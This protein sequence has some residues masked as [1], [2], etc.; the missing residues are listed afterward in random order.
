MM[1]TSQA[2]RAL[3][4]AEAMEKAAGAMPPPISKQPTPDWLDKK[5][6]PALANPLAGAAGRGGASLTLKPTRKPSAATL[7]ANQLGGMGIASQGEAAG[8]GW[9]PWLAMP[10]P[11]SSETAQFQRSTLTE[12]VV[13]KLGDGFVLGG[14]KDLEGAPGDGERF[15]PTL[16][17]VSVWGLTAKE[18]VNDLEGNKIGEILYQSN[19]IR[20]LQRSARV[21][22]N[23]GTTLFTFD[24]PKVS[25][26]DKN[27]A[28]PIM[29]HGTT[30]Y[31]SVAV[32]ASPK[33]QNYLQGQLTRLDG[34]GGLRIGKRFSKQG[35]LA[36]LFAAFCFPTLIL[37]FGCVFIEYLMQHM[38]VIIALESLDGATQFT[39]MLEVKRKQMVPFQS[40]AFPLKHAKHAKKYVEEKSPQPLDGAARIDALILFVVSKAALTLCET[41][42]TPTTGMVRLETV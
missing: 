30:P 2:D 36:C 9:R 22:V 23:D 10:M 27:P 35:Y 39:P 6:H 34:S 20:E 21:V 7:A 13:A 33:F 12:S 24:R 40:A 31:A 38:P 8:S 25:K 29:L 37:V 16:G 18:D 11:E 28:Y 42:S 41:E 32:D 26:D 17:M 19:N 1:S 14:I 15:I 5:N 3:E 4:E